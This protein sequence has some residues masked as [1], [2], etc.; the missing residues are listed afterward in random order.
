MIINETTVDKNNQ[1]LSDDEDEMPSEAP[2]KL[3]EA[4]D[5]VRRLHILAATEQPQLHYLISQ[6]DFQLTQV[7]LDSKGVKQTKI[8]DYF[9]KME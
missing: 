2:P 4:M 9:Q 1:Y 7:F 3:V 6:L 5:M 8:D